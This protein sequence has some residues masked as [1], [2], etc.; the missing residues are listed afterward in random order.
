MVKGR[1]ENPQQDLANMK[2][3]IRRKGAK[4]DGDGRAGCGS[5]DFYEWIVTLSMIT[6]ASIY[7]W[8]YVFNKDKR[9][10]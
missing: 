8:Q 10:I 9:L 4:G 5:L 1:C 6:V 3:S 7:Y 2:L